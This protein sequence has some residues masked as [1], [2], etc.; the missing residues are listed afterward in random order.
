MSGTRGL[1]P[2]AHKS[3]LTRPLKGRSSTV[4]SDDGEFASLRREPRDSNGFARH[5]ICRY[6]GA[7]APGA[8]GAATRYSKGRSSAV[9]PATVTLPTATMAS[10]DERT[11]AENIG[12]R[13]Y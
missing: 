1:K 3:R 7:N 9:S 10:G 13:V 12:G 6:I 5:A 2:L 8:Q 11:L 4:S